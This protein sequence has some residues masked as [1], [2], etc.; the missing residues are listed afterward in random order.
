MKFLLATNLQRTQLARGCTAEA[1]AARKRIYRGGN[2]PPVAICE[3]AAALYRRP[4]RARM[5]MISRTRPSPP[6]G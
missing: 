3:R 2:P 4:V 6:L 1:E 5:T